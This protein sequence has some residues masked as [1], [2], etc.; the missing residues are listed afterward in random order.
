VSEPAKRKTLASMNRA[1]TNHAVKQVSRSKLS[2]ALRVFWLARRAE[3]LVGIE[4][5]TTNNHCKGESTLTDQAD[6]G[7]RF[8]AVVHDKCTGLSAQYLPPMAQ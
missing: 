2:N 4:Y 1:G 6:R 7:L 5:T 3:Y 8:E